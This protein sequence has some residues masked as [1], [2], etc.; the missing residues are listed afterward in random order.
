MN[1]GTKV[2][3]GAEGTVGAQVNNET[4]FGLSYAYGPLSLA[5]CAPCAMTFAA[6]RRDRDVCQLDHRVLPA[7]FL[8]GREL[9]GKIDGNP[10]SSRPPEQ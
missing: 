1:N 5:R 2:A 9:V 6:G 10:N 4:T 3:V 8:N 7:R